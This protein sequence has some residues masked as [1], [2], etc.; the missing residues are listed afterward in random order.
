MSIYNVVMLVYE[1]KVYI[2]WAWLI[3]ILCMIY[4]F[5]YMHTASSSP[6]LLRV[7]REVE[8]NVY[9]FQKNGN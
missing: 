7:L 8:E 5:I 9:H 3:Y 2:L 6:E 1:A 4:L